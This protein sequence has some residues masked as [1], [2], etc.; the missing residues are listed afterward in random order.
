MPGN[1]GGRA[2]AEQGLW[3]TLFGFPQ[4]YQDGMLKILSK[5]RLSLPLS[6]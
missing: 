3:V 6:L 2:P 1:A 4:G 5:L